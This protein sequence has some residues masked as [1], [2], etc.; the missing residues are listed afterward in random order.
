MQLRESGN[1]RTDKSWHHTYSCCEFA[2]YGDTF[3]RA[4]AYQET[5]SDFFTL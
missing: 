3:I 2:V 5:E 4:R 1:I